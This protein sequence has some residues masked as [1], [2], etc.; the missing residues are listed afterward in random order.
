MTV[1]TGFIKGTG[2]DK[3]VSIG[4]IPDYVKIVNLT[5]GDKVW[6]NWLHKVVVFSSGGT[7]EI[8]AGDTI[9]GATS[10]ATGV[11]RQVI[12]DTGSW[13]GGDAAGWFIFEPDGITGTYQTE[14]AYINGGS[15]D[16]ATIAVQDNDG[17]D[18]DTEVAGTTTDDTNIS[19]YAGATTASKGFKIGAT[20]SEDAKLLGY[21]AYRSDDHGPDVNETAIP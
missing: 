17:I 10:L 3:N 7:T 4:F 14:A 2:A 11:V 1:K 9:K 5:D 6:E 21:I 15:T 19:H 18:I 20:I 16:Y 12:L 13:A 8:K